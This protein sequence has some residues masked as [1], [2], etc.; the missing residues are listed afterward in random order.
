MTNEANTDV[1]DTA[2]ASLEPGRI[3]SAIQIDGNLQLT[4]YSVC[5]ADITPAPSTI[6]ELQFDNPA[7]PTS[8]DTALAKSPPKIFLLGNTY[9]T[10]SANE[11]VQVLARTE[12]YDRSTLVGGSGWVVAPED[13]GADVPFSHPFGFDWE[14][15][16]ALDDGYIALL[17]PAN[18]EQEGDD[19]NHN[20]ILLANALGLSAP[21]GPLGVEWDK[22]LLPQSF[23]GQVNH[24]DRVAILGRWILDAGHVSSGYYKTEIHPPLL[25][26]TG[27]IQQEGKDLPFTRVLFMS[28]PYLAGQTYTVD[29]TDAYDDAAED[30]GPL[31]IHLLR[32]L[33]RVLLLVPSGQIEAHPKIKSYPFRCAHRFHIIV[34]PPPPPDS[35][36]Y[37]LAVSFQFTARSGCNVQVKSTAEDTVDVFVSLDD[38]EYTP[39]PLPNRKER[40][41]D[42]GE[43]DKL[44]SGSGTA[45]DVID[46]SQVA[47]VLFEKGIKTDEYD[48]LSEFNILDSGNAVKNELADNIPAGLGMT[49]DNTQPYPIFGWLEAKWVPKARRKPT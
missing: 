17:S 43:L 13:S 34:R 18:A 38:A 23:R 31:F 24:G 25:L 42:G 37:R 41:Y 15:Q 12:E 8:N 7:L 9:P 19:P 14:F 1:T 6:L 22:G 40:T 33:S 3:V 4:T 45:I 36:D 5:D 30:D 21:R 2:L 39:P 10:A 49:L 46:I 47:N 16:I 26:A 44:S 29:V 48:K 28:R 20:P 35:G 11:W 27:S 32:E